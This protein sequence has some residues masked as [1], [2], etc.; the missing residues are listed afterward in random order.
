MVLRMP[1]LLIWARVQLFLMNNIPLIIMAAGVSSRMKTSNVSTD[2][3][4]DQ[5]YQSN[6]RAK[7]FIEINEKNETL[8]YHIIKNSITAEIQDFYVIL[9]EDSIEFQNYLK[10]IEKK[11]SIKIR[12]AFQDYYGNPKPMGTADAIYQAMNQFP[13]L[14]SSRFLV[15][16]SDN[17]YSVKAIK[18]LKSEFTHN[19]MIAYNSKCLEFSEEKISSFS[20]LEIKNKFLY[21]IIEKPTINHIRNITDKKF[22]SMNIFSFFGDQVYDYLSNCEISQDRGEKEI[23]TAIQNMINDRNESIK[24]FKICEHVPDLTY[25]NDIE[26]INNFL[27]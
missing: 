5:V 8:I 23:A 12:F 21:K 6:S 18:T 15:C 11:L 25:K 9:S 16:N 4:E 10:K 26:L 22:I 1:S 19:S 17:I 20:I 13:I 3:S 24:V 14:K 7:G 2:L 27:K